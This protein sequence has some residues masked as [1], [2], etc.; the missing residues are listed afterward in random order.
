MLRYRT[1]KER[2]RIA[3]AV[4]AI[5]VTAAFMLGPKGAF[6]LLILGLGHVAELAVTGDIEASVIGAIV[7][8]LAATVN[9]FVPVFLILTFTNPRRPRSSDEKNA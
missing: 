9:W 6:P 5:L 3:V 4:S 2:A 8:F 1:A 7:R